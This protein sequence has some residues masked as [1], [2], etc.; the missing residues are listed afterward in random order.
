MNTVLNKRGVSGSSIILVWVVVLCFL[1]F[2]GLC[3]TGG[4]AKASEVEPKYGG[5]I[6]AGTYLIG[7]DPKGF[8][9]SMA[10]YNVDHYSSFYSEKLLWGDWSKGP[11]GTKEWDFSTTEWFPANVVVGCLA[12]SFQWTD[13]LTL[14]FKLRKGVKFHSGPPANGRELEAQDVVYSWDRLLKSPR[15]APKRFEVIESI[16]APDKY[17]AV[18]KLNKYIGEW[19]YLLGYGA[20][21]GIYPR[22]MVEAGPEDWKNASGT[23]PYMIKDYVRGSSITYVRNPDYWGKVKLGG[24]EYKLP[25]ADKIVLP[26]IR[27]EATQ[28]AALRS[29][30]LDT[31]YSVTWDNAE[32]LAETNPDLGRKGLIV[33]DALQIHFEMDRKP[34]TDIRVRKALNMAVDRDAIGKSLYGGKYALFSYPFLA[35]WPETLFTPVEKLPS[36]IREN[37]IFNQE[38]ARKLLRAAGYPEGFTT[39]LVYPQSADDVVQMISA[40]WSQIG[41]K[42]KLRLV[43]DNQIYSIMATK[44]FQ[45]MIAVHDGGSGPLVAMRK[46]TPG[47]FW[48]PGD[49]N[50]PKLIELYETIRQIR[51]VDEMNRK[52][53][54]ANVYA[55]SLVPRF[56]TPAPYVYNYWQ[57]WIGGFHG[58]NCIGFF[59]PAGVLSRIWIDTGM[60]KE[61]KGVTR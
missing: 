8:D 15:I 6:V 14:V 7:G 49:I 13:P 17:T 18:F 11:M 9:P 43:D 48:N 54:E 21:I 12:E 46:Q 56:S 2:T 29:G 61:M 26:I 41:V 32:S 36:H 40:Y 42:T 19:R 4:S 33:P 60:L 1:G 31:L 20:Y 45:G 59:N 47:E 37:Y 3:I 25:F 53:K 57:P 38:N 51:D 52:L 39:N 50:D 22:E 35:F 10:N 44:K 55:L 5:T 30:K 24:K 27:D 34:F 58:E 16:T 28:V 23:G